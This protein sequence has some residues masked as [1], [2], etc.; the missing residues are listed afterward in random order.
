MWRASFSSSV[1][2][3][4]VTL[5]WSGIFGLG[6]SAAPLAAAQEVHQEFQE[7]VRAEVLEVLDE[8]ERRIMGTDATTTVQTLRIEL[9]GGQ[10]A[11]EVVRFENDVTELAVGNIIFVNRLVGQDGVEYF[12]FKDIERRPQ[13]LVVS[14]LFVGLVLFFARWQGARALLSL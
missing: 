9:L 5:L 6:L 2:R 11:G 14:L 4:A 13:L 3:L 10:R 1:R 12:A 8:D 7:R